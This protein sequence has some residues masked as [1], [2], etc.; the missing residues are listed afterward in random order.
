MTEVWSLGCQYV[1]AEDRGTEMAAGGWLQRTDIAATQPSYSYQLS[2]SV[3]VCVFVSVHMFIDY[4][5][6]N[7]T[8]SI[9]QS[10]DS[11]C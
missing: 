10:T 5:H 6:E 11:I 9:S 2:E 4:N 7:C 1:L 8:I 3:S